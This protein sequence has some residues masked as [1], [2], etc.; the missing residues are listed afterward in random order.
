VKTLAALLLVAAC[1]SDDNA[2][3]DAAMPDAPDVPAKAATCA[4]SFGSALTDAFGRIDGTVLAVVP[5]NL[6][7]CA[8][9]N[10]THLVLQISMQG[11]AYRMVLNVDADISTRELDAPLAGPAWADGWHVDAPLDY[12]TTLGAHS[13]DFAKPADP[14]A[15][16][17]G[18]LELGAHV[19][20][21]ATS[22]GGTKAD[23]A[24]LVHRNLTNADGAI[25]IAPDTAPHYVLFKFDNQTF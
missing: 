24:H 23:S 8:Q 2:L 15:L 20:V 19:S 21:Y 16:V 25:V 14:V 5:P 1:G 11:A 6:Q 12:V 18:Q 17:T 4:S 9:P 10:M 13:A 3:P 22:T 7:T